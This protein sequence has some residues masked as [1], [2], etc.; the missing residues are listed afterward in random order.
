MQL[1]YSKAHSTL[2]TEKKLKAMS[3]SLSYQYYYPDRRKEKTTGFKFNSP[4]QGPWSEFN[5]YRHKN[6]QLAQ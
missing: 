1:A 5:Q 2:A 4:D 6:S 3:V